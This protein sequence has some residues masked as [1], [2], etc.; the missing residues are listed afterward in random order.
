MTESVKEDAIVE[1]KKVCC[2]AGYRFLLR[3]VDWT[4]K[5]GE[6]WVVFG[7]NGSGKTTLLSIIAG[8]KHYTKGTVKVFGEEYNND[9][10][11]GIRRKIGLVS[12]SFF[13]K[14]Y[15][16]ESI[17]NIVLS[18]KHGTLSLDEDITLHDVRLAKDLL[19]ELKLGDKIDYS[20]DTLSKGERQNVLIA[21]ALFSNPDILILDEPCTGLDIYNRS[22]LF[23]TIEEL[24]KRKELTIIYVTHYVEEIIPLF[25][26]ILLL[27]Q[28]T[29]YAQGNTK[30]L[31]R[32]DIFCDFL[33][34]PV[35]ITVDQNGRY[36]AQVKTSSNL[37]QLL[38]GE[39]IQ[40]SDK[41][42]AEGE[43]QT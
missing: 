23:E 18:G 32:E 30:D 13:D 12:A 22:Y 37:I 42:T 34:Y 41:Q 6:H 29:V 9:N 24:S 25:D 31:I 5:P 36:Q 8:F 28:G 11:L 43:G 38:Y 14:H 33:G 7:M 15:T 1:V 3:D 16:K 35:G 40:P 27:R 39:T 17:L 2:K 20:F 4:V 21:R 10:I 19:C 26:K